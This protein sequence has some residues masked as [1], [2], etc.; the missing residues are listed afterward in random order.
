MR[1]SAKQFLGGLAILVLPSL[2]GL[3]PTKPTRLNGTLPR[4]R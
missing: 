1:W 3:G 4:P 2:F